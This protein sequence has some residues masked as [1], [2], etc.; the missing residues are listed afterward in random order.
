MWQINDQLRTLAAVVA[1]FHVYHVKFP[2]SGVA[3]TQLDSTQRAS[4][5]A[6]AKHLNV[7]IYL[8]T[9]VYQILQSA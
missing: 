9:S 5:D 7:H 8:V 4:M 3:T 6:G 1:N 2:L